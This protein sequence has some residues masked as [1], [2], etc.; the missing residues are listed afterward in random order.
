MADNDVKL[1]YALLFTERGNQGLESGSEI[2][3]TAENLAKR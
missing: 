3:K 2:R 1:I